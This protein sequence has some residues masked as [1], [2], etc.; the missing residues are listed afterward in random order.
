MNNVKESDSKEHHAISN[1]GCIGMISDAERA[2]ITCIVCAVMEMGFLSK[3]G[4]DSL[5]LINAIKEGFR[6]ALG[7]ERSTD[8]PYPITTFGFLETVDLLAEK[9]FDYY[10]TKSH[11][12]II[13]NGQG[14]KEIEQ[15]LESCKAKGYSHVY[16]VEEQF[17]IDAIKEK[18]QRDGGMEDAKKT[19]T[20]AEDESGS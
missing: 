10:I 19:Q 16:C 1:K 5:F 18:L 13:K 20:S 3:C 12:E 8:L 6:R 14:R 4:V 17:I 11:A 2:G 7:R 15:I 9:S